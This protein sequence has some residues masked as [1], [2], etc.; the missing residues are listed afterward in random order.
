MLGNEPRYEEEC[1]WVFEFRNANLLNRQTTIQISHFGNSTR[2]TKLIII[3]HSI[4]HAN[5]N[6]SFVANHSL[7]PEW[8]FG[9]ITWL[10]LRNKKLLW[11]MKHQLWWIYRTKWIM[12]V[13][14]NLISVTNIAITESCVRD[15]FHNRNVCQRDHSLKRRSALRPFVI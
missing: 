13:A 10:R 3:S 1:I 14:I 9:L 5:S 6:F 4:I 11:W 7:V 2:V 12:K 8:W 15:K